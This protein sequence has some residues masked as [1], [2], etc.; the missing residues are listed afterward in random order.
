MI[1]M[2]Y[3]PQL[4]IPMYPKIPETF[5][6]ISMGNDKLQIRGAIETVVLSGS[7]LVHVLTDLLDG[8]L[9]IDEIV[10]VIYNLWEQQTDLE[11]VQTASN[12][13][14]E[15]ARQAIQKKVLDLLIDFYMNGL[16]ED[17]D[18]ETKEKLSL[19]ELNYYRNQILF[20]S[21]YVDV[22]RASIS[23]YGLQLSLKESRV[24]VFSSGCFGKLLVS[25]LCKS[26]LGSI[27]VINMD[28]SGDWSNIETLNPYVSIT[29]YNERIDRF[30]KLQSV[31]ANKE[32][33]L[34]ILA[35]N[36][37]FPK[38]YQWVNTVCIGRRLPWTISSIHGREAII[39][40]TFYPPQTGCYTCFA[41]RQ[42][43][44]SQSP[45]EEQA[46]EE[47]LNSDPDRVTEFE[48]FSDMASS[49]FTIEILKIITFFSIPSTHGNKVLFFDL[50]TTQTTFSK[51]LKIPRCPSCS[52]SNAY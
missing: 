21:K 3:D 44:A 2:Y 48:H 33:N 37:P 22:T 12:T 46:Y 45:V 17:E 49:L 25:R 42:K 9:S 41:S 31:F 16:L 50:L 34:A 11:L 52:S 5:D 51:F 32:F 47:Y 39:G 20:F 27:T 19:E 18:V 24:V 8:S 26:G 14:K 7:N 38:L 6:R 13:V 29:V 30:E 10:D 35:T 28:D 43:A 40:P 1:R 36:R 23:R 15:S 4:P